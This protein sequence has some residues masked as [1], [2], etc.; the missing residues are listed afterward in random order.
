[1]ANDEEGAGR[2]T[3]PP[4]DD[5]LSRRLKRLDARL[6]EKQARPA[7]PGNRGPMSPSDPTALARAFRMS[8]EFVAGIIAG[9]GIGW[10]FDRLLGTS[11][12][13]L[14]VFLML[15]FAAGIF[16]VLRAAGLQ[17]GP[18]TGGRSDQ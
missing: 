2:G 1:M 10:L 8:T 18:R 6:D 5:D 4:P 13:G 11:P 15:G 14:I 9:A 17:T 12:G 3:S 16:N 7:D